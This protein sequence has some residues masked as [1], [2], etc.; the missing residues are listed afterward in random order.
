ME[1]KVIFR[2]YQE[3]QAQDH[4][5]LQDYAQRSFDHLVL[6]AVSGN[7]RLFAGFA[8]T[9]TGQTEVQIAPGRF[10]DVLGVIYALNNTTTQS[11]VAYLAAARHAIGTLVTS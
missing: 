11:M 10:Y 4:N 8:V 2:D 1:S 7:T 5:D 3:Q 9:K 6:D